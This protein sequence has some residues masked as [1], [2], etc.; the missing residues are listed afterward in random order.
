MKFKVYFLGLLILAS[1]VACKNE[2]AQN[3]LQH[4]EVI[5]VKIAPVK[6]EVKSPVFHTSGFFTTN[7]ETPLSFLSSGIVEKIYVDEGDAIRKG[8]LLATLKGVVAQTSL[9]QAELSY[10]KAKRDYQRA[11]NLYR[12]S[13]ATLE[14]MQ[15]AKTALAVAEQQKRTAAF[16]MKHTEIRATADG[17]VLRRNANEGEMVGAGTPVL[18]VNTGVGKAWIFK[19]SV[20][21]FQWAALQVGD[22]AV[23]TTDVAKGARLSAKVFKKSKGIDPQTG[24]FTIQLQIEN[25]ANIPLASGLFG[26]A[27]LYPS[28]VINVWKIPY[29]ALL[30]GDGNQGFVFVTTDK[31]HAKKIDVHVA[32][33]AHDAVWI[34]H[35][36]EKATHVIVSGSAYLEDG[37]K[38]EVNSQN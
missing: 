22:S 21:D 29:E 37:S 16:N 9:E 15:N 30:D 1:L 25:T 24:G 3:G 6:Q 12:D 20:N 28:T 34:D 2:A 23:L 4:G 11:A 7:N 19:T 13:V 17:Y 14:Q 32:R 36:L 35:G 8:Q 26:E 33:I 31:K 38:I 10:Q 18:L 27:E 5:P